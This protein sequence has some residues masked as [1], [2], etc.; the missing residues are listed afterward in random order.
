M[1]QHCVAGLLYEQEYIELTPADLAVL[2]AGTDTL[3]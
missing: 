3:W 1:L 2:V